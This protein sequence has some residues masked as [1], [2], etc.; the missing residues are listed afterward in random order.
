[1]V[2]VGR[3]RWLNRKA[4]FI[5]DSLSLEY[6]DFEEGMFKASNVTLRG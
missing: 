1:M 4:I 3:K 2:D 6:N 5:S